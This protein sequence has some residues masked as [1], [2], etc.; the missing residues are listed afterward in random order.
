MTVF[1][2][3]PGSG[4]GQTTL[5]GAY[6]NSSGADPQILLNAT[7]TPISIEASVAGAVLEIRDVGNA[8]TI[9]EVDADPDLII[10][11]SGVT[12]EDAFTNGGAAS[13]LT[14]ADTFTTGGG[15]LGGCILSNGT[16]TYDNSFFIWALLQESKV[17][18]AAAGPGFAAFTLFNALAVIQNQGNFDLVQALVLNNGVAHSRT[19]AGTSTV[20]QTIGLSDSPSSRATVSGAVLTRSIGSIAVNSGH[21]FSTVAGS[22]VNLGT[23]TGLRC[24]QPAVALFQ[25]QAGTE[26]ITARYGLDWVNHTFG[27]ASAVRSVVRS[28]QAS[29]ANTYFL[30]HTGTAESRL[31]GPL[32]FPNDFPNGIIRMGAGTD[33]SMGYIGAEDELYMQIVNP[34]VTQWRFASPGTNRLRIESS[35]FSLS[36]IN[37]NYDRFSLGAQAGAN[38]NQVGNFVTGA[39]T[40]SVAGDWADFLLTQGGNLTVSGLAMGR[41]SAWVINGVSYANST[42]SVGNADTLTVGG[43]PTSSPGV[44]ITERQSLNVIGGRSR[45]QAAMQ[46]DP[47]NPAALSAGDNNDWAGLLTG[48]ANNGM[49]HWARVTPDGGGTSVITGIDSTAAQDGDTFK[50]TNIGTVNLTI[51]H[52]DA[53]SAASNRIISPTVADYVLAGTQSVEL[54][55]DATTDRW[56]IL[57]GSGT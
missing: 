27:G 16:V 38:G 56:R 31:G 3:S 40:L 52:Q 51:G 21:T 33:F 22:T 19:S 4:A 26:N 5:Q 2:A 43:F 24:I 57:Y 18:N 20:S 41:I 13:Y 53:G 6:D 37:L 47:I 34:S 36:E 39:R 55:W 12:I 30:D 15:Y 29:G 8:N 42:G 9:F 50:L 49:R 11:R 28:D 32:N 44:T 23:V 17:Y 46:F 14:F 45:H 35:S 25:P 1:I 10:A 54:I 48:S 7:P